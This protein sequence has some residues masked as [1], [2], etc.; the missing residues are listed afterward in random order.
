[1]SIR[2]PFLSFLKKTQ[3]LAR[4]GERGTMKL[5]TLL[6]RISPPGDLASGRLS[7]LQAQ[8]DYLV[9]DFMIRATDW[10]SMGAL[11][12]GGIA[13]RLGRIGANSTLLTRPVSLLAG[14]GVEVSAFEMTHRS[15]TS[16]NSGN[17]SNP[18]V[19]RWEGQGGIRQGL[20]SSLI[21]F[22]SLKGAGGLSQ[23]ENVVVQHLLQDTAMVLGHQ[24]SG[25]FGITERSQGN[26]AEQFLHAEAV[27]LQLSAGMALAYSI[28]P[29]IQGLERG[30]NLSLSG[31]DA[32]I[33]LP[34]G[35][36]PI[37]ASVGGR[38]NLSPT[39]LEKKFEPFVSLM[40]ADKP[41]GGSPS[42]KRGSSSQPP[43]QGGI[44]ENDALAWGVREKR[45]QEDVDL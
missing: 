21:T 42:E 19:W 24:V 37:F 8:V 36:Q 20:L 39:L 45:P 18:N 14:L 10:R 35:F 15:L 34:S 16:L 31:G 25:A 1:M 40:S 3:D 26:L 4:I 7:P 30:L 17:H 32:G 43:L 27:N 23:G 5:E 13:G 9:E 6:S 28:A 11:A 22:A 38:L 29:G 41:E 2:L 33:P 12:T 44:L